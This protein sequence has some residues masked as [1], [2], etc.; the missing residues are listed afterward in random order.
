MKNSLFRDCSLTGFLWWG[1]N[2]FRRKGGGVSS[3]I[4]VAAL[5]GASCFLFS[6]G[7]GR[8]SNRVASGLVIPHLEVTV[9][10]PVQSQVETHYVQ[11]GD[12]VEVNTVL[13]QLFSRIEQL[14]MARAKAVMENAEFIFQSTESLY[15]DRVIS[16]DEWLAS[17]IER[18]LARLQHEGAREAVAMREIRSPIQGMVVERLFEAGETVRAADPLFVIIDFERIF[19]QVFIGADQLPFLS[20]GQAVRVRFPELQISEPKEGVIDFIDPRVDP[21]SG[22]LKVKVLVDNKDRAIKV[23]VR[24]VVEFGESSSGQ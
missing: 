17:R 4:P 13:S 22:L 12:M 15:Q 11:Q 6:E 24:G 16:E 7:D 20:S 5:L 1:R 18:D 9:S 21:A 2:A 19:V 8:T 3:R 23:G 14:D 10:S